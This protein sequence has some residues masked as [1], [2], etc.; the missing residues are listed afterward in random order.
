MA[1]KDR[2]FIGG[3]FALIRMTAICFL[4]AG[5]GGN[6]TE[7]VNTPNPN[8]TPPS[9]KFDGPYYTVTF[10]IPEGWTYIDYTT[11]AEAGAEAFTDDDA[12]TGPMAHFLHLDNGFFTVFSALLD[13]GET[14]LDYV[15]ER[16]PVGD[17]EIIA[18]ESER[19]RGTLAFFEQEEAGPRGGYL[20]DVYLAVGLEVLWMRTE[21][22]GSGEEMEET[23]DRFW[24]IVGSATIE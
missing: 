3:F 7:V 5:C 8:E 10:E 2:W 12:D 17:I 22:L 23:W 20:F 16:R 19:Q 18:L 21:L 15:R 14:L 4:L 11:G 1:L 6:G 9:K 13:E 24:E